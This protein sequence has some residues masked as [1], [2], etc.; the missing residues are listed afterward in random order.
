MCHS[1]S[2]NNEL[3]HIHKRALCIVCED[4]QSRISALLVKDNSF[5][6]YQK[7]LELLAIEIFKVKMNISSEITNKI[8]NFSKKSVYE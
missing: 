8:V 1:R 3:N 2:L 7:N 6:I 4:F 5:T